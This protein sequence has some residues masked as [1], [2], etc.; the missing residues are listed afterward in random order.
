MGIEQQPPWD[1]RERDRCA[2]LASRHCTGW[3]RSSSSTTKNGYW[4]D[5]SAGCGMYGVLSHSRNPA[6]PSHL[7]RCIFTAFFHRS[8]CAVW[9]PRGSHRVK[10]ADTGT[11]SE[12]YS[13]LGIPTKPLCSSSSSVGTASTLC[14]AGVAS[15]AGAAATAALPSLLCEAG[16]SADRT[17]GKKNT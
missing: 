11:W 3:A 8:T 14:T 5:L 15:D 13:A 1:A 7:S 16:T 17:S 9:E 4:G 2:V 12:G 10:V 6:Q